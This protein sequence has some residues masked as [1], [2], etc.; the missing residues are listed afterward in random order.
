MIHK[1]DFAIGSYYNLL[2]FGLKC[3][4]FWLFKQS[5]KFFA[6]LQNILYMM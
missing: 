3:Q 6:K 2:Q 5:I 1:L 4:T